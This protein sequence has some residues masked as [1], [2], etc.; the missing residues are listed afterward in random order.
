MFFVELSTITETE[1]Y[2]IQLCPS[3]IVGSKDRHCGIIGC[4]PSLE[5]WIVVEEAVHFLSQRKNFFL[6]FTKQQNL[7]FIEIQVLSIIV[8]LLSRNNHGF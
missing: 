7:I 4:Q 5:N 3:V 1:E 8:N 2:K 6:A